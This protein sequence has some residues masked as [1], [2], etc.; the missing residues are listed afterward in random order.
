MSRFAAD[1][2]SAEHLFDT[3]YPDAGP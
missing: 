3:S 2:G 1:L